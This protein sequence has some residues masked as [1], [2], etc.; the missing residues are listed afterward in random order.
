MSHASR[1]GRLRKLESASPERR[2]E[3]SAAVIARL[4]AENPT[5][6][7]QGADW[8][9]MRRA[10]AGLLMTDSCRASVSQWLEQREHCDRL[11]EDEGPAIYAMTEQAKYLYRHGRLPDGETM[12][13]HGSMTA[14]DIAATMELLRGTEHEYKDDSL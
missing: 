3:E 6:P 9:A 12:R 1:E 4:Y 5:A 8:K 11:W 14:A 7:K 10:F 13:T 2:F